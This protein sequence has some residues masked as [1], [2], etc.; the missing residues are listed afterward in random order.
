M[1]TKIASALDKR[2]GIVGGGQLGKM[3][4]EASAAWNV[5]CN[6]LENDIK[7]PAVRHSWQFIQGKLTDGYSIRAL[8]EISDVLTYEIE[9][10]DVDTLLKLEKNG[11]EVYP[12][13]EN[14]KII[15]DKGVQKE[16]YQSNNLPTAPYALVANEG[17]WMAALDSL[18]GDKIVV[19][20]RTGGY[21]GKGVAI[22]D[23]SDIRNGKPPFP[24]TEPCVL[25]QFID[26]AV[27]LSVIVARNKSGEVVTYPLAEMV[28][29]PVS[30]L[31]NTLF[32]P[33]KV[34]TEV[35]NVA[36]DVSL[37]AVELMNGIGLFAVELF[38]TPKGEIF[39]NE[40][41]PRPHNSGHHTIEACYTSQYE[42]LLRVLLDLPLGST[43]LICPAVMVNVVGDDSFSGE[44][45]LD[46][47]EQILAIQGV[48]VHM[49]DKRISK[50]NRKLGHITILNKDL[51]NALEKAEMVKELI[52]IV[53]R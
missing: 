40:I 26:D 21:D 34:T 17:E 22:C 47:I 18:P 8:A 11:T 16:H 33:A 32:S 24:F 30:N 12:S 31:V 14:L 3:L 39:I 36:R 19:K 38:L 45:F 42:Q 44:Y 6:I 9:H 50:P 15:Q 29:D 13:P 37:K 20:S 27:E 49:Y 53:P 10:I 7:A 41:A 52:A 48:Y 5:K 23:K 35:E 2:I 25:E 46:N 28:F 1:D 51:D 43:D 4:I